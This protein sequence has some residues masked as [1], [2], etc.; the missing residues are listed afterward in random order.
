M[1]PEVFPRIV[2]FFSRETVEVAIGT[3]AGIIGSDTFAEWLTR[4]LGLKGNSALI[5]SIITKLGLGGVLSG[6]SGRMAPGIMRVVLQY[7]AVGAVVS[8]IIDLIRR[9]MPGIA[10]PGE[11]LGVRLRAPTPVVAGTTPVGGRVVV[12]GGG[13]SPASTPSPAVTLT[14]L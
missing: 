11:A 5:V 13:S 1:P 9:Y 8:I 10:A 2:E 12:V 14:S 3:S 6:I 4:Q 7:A